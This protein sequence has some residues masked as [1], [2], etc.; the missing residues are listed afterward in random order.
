M[1]L[2]RFSVAMPASRICLLTIANPGGVFEHHRL[3]AQGNPALQHVQNALSTPDVE[4]EVVVSAR[5][6]SGLLRP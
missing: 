3:V 6:S 5:G 2:P 1:P 4:A